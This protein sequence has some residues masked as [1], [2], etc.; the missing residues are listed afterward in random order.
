MTILF[1]SKKFNL[2]CE[3]FKYNLGIDLAFKKSPTLNGKYPSTVLYVI[4]HF[5]PSKVLSYNS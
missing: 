4:T 3:K 5:S 2:V 1:S